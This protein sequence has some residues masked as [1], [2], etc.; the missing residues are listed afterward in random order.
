MSAT[1]STINAV[2]SDVAAKAAAV[3]AARQRELCMFD[4]ARARCQALIDDFNESPIRLVPHEGWIRLS[5]HV[6]YGSGTLHANTTRLAA[7]MAAGLRPFLV[8]QGS[9][10]LVCCHNAA[11]QYSSELVP[12]DV[13]KLS[14]DPTQRGAEI[15]ANNAK[16]IEF[17]QTAGLIDLAT[18][19]RCLDQ[20]LAAKLPAR[21]DTVDTPVVG[22]VM[23]TGR[24][25]ID[26]QT[27]DPKQVFDS[28]ADFI[29][30]IVKQL[31]MY[32]RPVE[33]SVKKAKGKK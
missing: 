31:A 5:P 27:C 19:Q 29:G 7:W 32:L 23:S 20:R 24:F 28:P 3:E 15:S 26:V 12:L 22:V 9:N 1:L 30:A 17:E 16:R 11:A 13:S 4:G 18:V 14:Q 2:H 6:G 21:Y 25:T 33:V 8:W 10:A